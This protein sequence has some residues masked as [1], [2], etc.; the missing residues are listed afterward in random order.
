MPSTT[1][2]MASPVATF[3]P[4]SWPTLFF[5]CASST[6]RMNCNCSFVSS[7]FAGF[8]LLANWASGLRSPWLLLS[9]MFEALCCDVTRGYF[10][11]QCCASF[12]Q[13]ALPF[14]PAHKFSFRYSFRQAIIIFCSLSWY[15]DSYVNFNM[16]RL[17]VNIFRSLGL[18]IKNNNNK[19]N[20]LNNRL[21]P[22]KGMLG[23]SKSK[24]NKKRRYN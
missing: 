18:I 12:A 4:R 7:S 3:R 8:I 15:N 14:P 16:F 6:C 24:T 11:R 1:A 17:L 21:Y 5:H 23:A 19:K 22:R 10:T 20:F 13:L 2:P 9:A